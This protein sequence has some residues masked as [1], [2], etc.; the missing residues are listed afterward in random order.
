MV[1]EK[2][3]NATHLIAN[4]EEPEGH[5]MNGNKLKPLWHELSVETTR[6]SLR[7]TDP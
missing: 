1:Q 6:L 7:K 2:W 3:A 4:V 5:I